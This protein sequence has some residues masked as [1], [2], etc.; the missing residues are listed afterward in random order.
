[1]SAKFADLSGLSESCG[2]I[3]GDGAGR[4]TAL[5][6]HLTMVDLLKQVDDVKCSLKFHFV[7]T[8]Y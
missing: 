5:L 1:M 7:K 6:H 2:T 4:V 8:F 3:F